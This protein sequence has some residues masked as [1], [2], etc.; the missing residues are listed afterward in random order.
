MQ[1]GG[2]E[3]AGRSCSRPAPGYASQID[4]STRSDFLYAAL[5]LSPGDAAVLSVLCARDGAGWTVVAGS[6]LAMP[7]GWAY[8]SWA[9]WAELQ[10]AVNRHADLAPGF[11]LGPN[12]DA[13][14]F[15]DVRIQRAVLR[16][17]E[18]R[19]VVDDL[20]GGRLRSHLLDAK[21]TVADWS[22]S[23]LLTG[24]GSTDAH[25][26]V[27]G[28]RRPVR[29]V[30]GATEHPATAP[31]QSTWEWPLPPH[32]RPGPELG[33]IAPGRRLLWWPRLLLG[34]D[35]LADPEFAPPSRF[36]VGRVQHSAWIVGTRPN[37]ET[38]QLDVHVGWDEHAI[39]PL[40]LSVL[41]R[42]ERDGLVLVAGQTRISDLPSHLELGPERQTEPR[43]VPWADRLLTVSLP[44]G[45]R[46]TDWGVA[47]I[48]GDGRLLDERPVAAR[49]EQMTVGFTV[50]DSSDA[51]FTSVVGDRRPAPGRAEQDEEV[52][53]LTELE[54]E[55]RRAA[56]ARRFS[57]SGQLASYLH[58]RFCCRAGELIVIDSYLMTDGDPGLRSHD[59]AFL[60]SLK[61]PIR[62]LTGRLSPEA[63]AEAAASDRVVLKRLPH[64]VRVHDR[65]WIV[66]E[67]GLLLGSS[68]NSFLLRPGRAKTLSTTASELP[69]ADAQ[70]WRE[71][72]EDWWD[73]SPTPDPRSS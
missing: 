62:A 15:P 16:L 54:T 61:R 52:R 23:V 70:L 59:L 48:S 26:V 71:R 56:A 53:L 43:D 47:L 10:P 50:G 69:H 24:E 22:P 60:E 17:A 34:I 41:V 20:E 40:G 72:F 46:R 64:G 42:S 18:L 57:D 12:F 8:T 21:L 13:Q 3:P 4:G 25:R 67:T 37:S 39:D 44:R 49:V 14:P 63:A 32:L 68:V 30:V 1:I 2:G 28:A 55:A 65:V 5:G 51:A 33:A 11:D 29:G 73:A 31:T 45:P 35:W 27:H 58:W 36:V 7:R 38:E 66:G 6:L 19:D 9:R